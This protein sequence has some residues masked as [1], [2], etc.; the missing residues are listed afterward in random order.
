VPALPVRPSKSLDDADQKRPCRLC[1]CG[2]L[3]LELLDDRGDGDDVP[4]ELELGLLEPGG[5][6]D[7]LREVQDRHRVVLPGRLAQLRLPRVER[8]VAQRAGRDDRVRARF[9]R[10]LDRLDQLAERDLLTG[11]DDRKAAA[12]DL[13]RVVDR[14]PAACLD[15]RLERPRPVR[16]LEPEELG[17]PQDLTAVE[18]RHLQA[19]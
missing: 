19:L 14:L 11:L 10:L 3:N 4:L 6:A 13:G 12:L 18:R 1:R 5:H 9:R 16:V 2:R 7:Q 15:D 8:E 17:R